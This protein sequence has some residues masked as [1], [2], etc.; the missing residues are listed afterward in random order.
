MGL[1]LVGDEH[2]PRLASRSR[3][4]PVGAGAKHRMAFVDRLLA[5]LVHLR[6]GTEHGVL[7][8]W[9]GVDCSTII[10]AISEVRPLLTE[11]GCTVST[12]DLG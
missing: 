8:C 2:Q 10:H 5:K 3:K 1:C 9:F 6:R 4:R 11:R 12:A 7:A